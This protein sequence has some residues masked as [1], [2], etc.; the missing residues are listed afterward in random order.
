VRAHSSLSLL[1]LGPVLQERTSTLPW[2]PV[3][4]NSTH[5]TLTLSDLITVQNNIHQIVGSKTPNVDAYSK[6]RAWIQYLLAIN[7]FRLYNFYV[8]TLP[9]KIRLFGCVD[10]RHVLGGRLANGSPHQDLRICN[11][12]MSSNPI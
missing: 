11:I 10:T 5:V 4:P 6:S 12:S 2:T 1:C 8:K 9:I 3:H 7:D